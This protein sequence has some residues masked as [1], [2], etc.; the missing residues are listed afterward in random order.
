MKNVFRE[1]RQWGWD[2]NGAKN[3]LRLPADGPHFPETDLELCKWSKS[4]APGDLLKSCQ[5]EI[6]LLNLAGHSLSK[7]ELRRWTFPRHRLQ[8]TTRNTSIW[9]PI[10]PWHPITALPLPS[11]FSPP[12]SYTTGH[13]LCPTWIQ[14]SSS[15]PQCNAPRWS[16]KI[17]E[18][19]IP[20]FSP[21]WLPVTAGD[22]GKDFQYSIE[23]MLSLFFVQRSTF[24]YDCHLGSL[25]LISDS[26]LHDQ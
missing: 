12:Y 18:L 8:P 17:F 1:G 26:D 20:S 23:I 24:H 16:A 7:Y 5:S 9:G 25:P 3:W 10:Q 22:C 13:R 14:K 11:N 4:A 2:P 21:S 19:P 6:A 15:I